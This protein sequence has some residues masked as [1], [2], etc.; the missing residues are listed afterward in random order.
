MVSEI[1]GNSRVRLIVL[2]CLIWKGIRETQNSKSYWF[3]KIIWRSKHSISQS[4]NRRRTW[5][6]PDFSVLRLEFGVYRA[7]QEIRCLDES[8]G[9]NG[10]FSSPTLQWRFPYFPTAEL[11]SHDGRIVQRPRSL[12]SKSRG[13]ASVSPILRSKWTGKI[14]IPG[15][16]ECPFRTLTSGCQSGL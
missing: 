10:F 14:G 13:T 7:K 3:Y 5:K 15:L 4:I 1:L 12:W 8:T 6:H 11:A 2:N 16:I 9:K